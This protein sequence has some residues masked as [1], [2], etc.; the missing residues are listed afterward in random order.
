MVKGY[1]AFDKDLRCRGFQYE[2][3]QTYTQLRGP[4]VCGQ[5][6]H[7][8]K[9]AAVV[10]DDD[11]CATDKIEIVRELTWEEFLTLC[12]TGKANSGLKNSGNR[13]TGNRNTGNRNTGDYNTGDYNTGDYNT[14]NRNTGDYNTGDYNTGDYNTGNRNTG[15]YNTGDYNTGDYNTGNRNTG[16]YNTGDYNTGDYNTGYGN[17]CDFSNGVFCTEEPTVNFFNK[18][19][20]MTLREFYNSDVRYTLDRYFILNKWI[21]ES[22]MTDEEKAKHP[23]YETIGGY[24]RSYSYKE[25]WVNAWNEMDEDEREEVKGLPNFT[26]ELF[27]EITG[28]EV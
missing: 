13:N 26:A 16:D 2:V 6:F 28:I 17:S 27:K 5:G 1:K 3:G 22:D 15:D 10:E 21:Y 23:E 9:S 20:S 8:C 14:G 12:N 24:I 7:F 19:S 4:V 18:P 25:A 11:K